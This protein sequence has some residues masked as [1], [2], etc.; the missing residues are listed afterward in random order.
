MADKIH[1]TLVRSPITCIPKHRRTLKALGL[2]KIGDTVVHED[3]E[4]IR[5]MAK[6]VYYLL[7]IEESK[8]KQAAQGEV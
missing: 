8:G 1:I 4:T 3:T 7:K 5:G 6:K 2:K